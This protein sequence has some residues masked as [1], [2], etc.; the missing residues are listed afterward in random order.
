MTSQDLKGIW[1]VDCMYGPGAQGDENVVFLENGFGWTEIMSWGSIS[2]ETFHWKIENARLNIKGELC[3]S[4]DEEPAPSS[5]NFAGVEFFVAEELTPSGKTMKV[6]N[7]S[8]QICLYN[9]KFGLIKKDVEADLF[10]MRQKLLEKK[11]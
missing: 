8:E 4:N 11:F 1:S 3:L 2:I 9:N 6:I 7:F 5:L 10:V